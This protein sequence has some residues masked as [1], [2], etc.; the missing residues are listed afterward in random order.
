MATSNN[1]QKRGGLG[2][3]TVAN[4]V[5]QVAQANRNRINHANKDHGTEGDPAI[6]I[7]L[8]ELGREISPDVLHPMVHQDL[9][10]ALQA[11]KRWLKVSNLCENL[12]HVGLCVTSILAFT[13][14]T[15]R[16]PAVLFANG[17]CSTLS[18]VL[19]KYSAYAA[20]ESAERHQV[21]L[22][23]LRY[24][25]LRDLPPVLVTEHD[26]HN[27]AITHTSEEE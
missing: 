7:A 3:R 26:D 2:L 5:Y 18:V 25:K 15:Y 10:S 13:A 1:E 4:H 21:I 24:L 8:V 22:K 23:T 6:E 11:R 16:N 19:L 17:C 12:A 14:S 20:G 27:G 9:L